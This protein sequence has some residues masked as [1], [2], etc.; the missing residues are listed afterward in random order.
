MHSLKG[1]A[2][3][4]PRT[5]GDPIAKLKGR[6]A[7]PRSAS[8]TERSRTDVGVR[9]AFSGNSDKADVSGN[10]RILPNGLIPHTTRGVYGERPRDV[11]GF[12]RQV[13]V[14]LRKLAP[15]PKSSAT[16]EAIRGTGDQKLECAATS[17][18]VRSAP[19]SRARVRGRGLREFA[20]RFRPAQ[21]ARR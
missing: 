3:P 16:P 9:Q 6:N 4:F 13:A 1:W 2:Q 10:G 7:A 20:R 17:P 12:F 18:W 11:F 8:P 14:D 15:A 19:S 5:G 21:S